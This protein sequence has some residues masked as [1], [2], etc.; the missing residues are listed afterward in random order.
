M[1][2]TI[3]EADK[4]KKIKKNRSIILA[5]RSAKQKK[6]N[7]WILIHGRPRGGVTVDVTTGHSWQRKRK[8]NLILVSRS[9]GGVIIK[10]IKEQST[11]V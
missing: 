5:S 6:K 10:K 11:C 2:T 1:T 9:I 3:H 4:L 8:K 7:I